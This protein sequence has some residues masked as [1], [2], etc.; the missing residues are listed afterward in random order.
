MRK[1]VREPEGHRRCGTSLRGGKDG[2][3]P[4]VAINLEV[5]KRGHKAI[6]RI[7]Q[8]TSESDDDIAIVKDVRKESQAIVLE[9]V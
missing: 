4:P 2:N 8:I 7:S 1:N 6:N 3:P 5:L 9:K